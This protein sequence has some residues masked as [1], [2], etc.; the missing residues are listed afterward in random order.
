[1][2]PHAAAMLALPVTA[3]LRERVRFEAPQVESPP[4]LLSSGEV[5]RFWYS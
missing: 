4:A 2:A 1:M 5:H 3:I